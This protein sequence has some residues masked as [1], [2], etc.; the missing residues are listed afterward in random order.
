MQR[1]YSLAHFTLLGIVVL[2]LTSLMVCI[3]VQ[4]QIAFSSNRNG[5]FEIYVMNIHGKNPRRLTNS[6]HN[7]V[8]PSWSP[9]G[10][11][12]AFSSKR[13]GGVT[14]EIYVMDADGGNPQRLTNNGH[15]DYSPSWSPDG[16][17]I[18]FYFRP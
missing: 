11:R 16:E 10:K 5:D 6:R 8:S 2:G 1:I 15:D 18:V 12:I 4:A 14:S 7:D 9:D 3:E 17:L 13:D